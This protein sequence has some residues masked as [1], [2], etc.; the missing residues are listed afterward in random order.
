MVNNFEP[1]FNFNLNFDF[2]GEHII[3]PTFSR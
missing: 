1:T 2:H 3:E